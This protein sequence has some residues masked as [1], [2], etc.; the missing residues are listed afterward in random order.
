MPFRG[1][2]DPRKTTHHYIPSDM[3]ETSLSRPHTQTRGSAFAIRGVSDLQQKTSPNPRT[4]AVRRR[5]N[6]ERRA[7]KTLPNPKRR[8]KERIRLRGYHP[9][10]RKN[11]LGGEKKKLR[12]RKLVDARREYNS[13][14]SGLPACRKRKKKKKRRNRVD[15]CR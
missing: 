3:Y 10:G 5:T 2:S 4:E 12:T 11:L 7:I 13:R 15:I 8:T 1:G 6:M 9:S 14:S